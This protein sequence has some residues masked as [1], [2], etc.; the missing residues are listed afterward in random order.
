M[1]KVTTTYELPEKISSIILKDNKEYDSL[2]YHDYVAMGR[3]LLKNIDCYQARIA[4]YACKICMIRHGGRST[5]FYTLT[6]YAKE[7]NIS[8]NTLSTWTQVYRHVIVRLGIPLEELTKKVWVTATRTQERLSWENRR[9]NSEKGTSR[10][11]IKYKPQVPKEKI[12]KIWK[13]EEDDKP[14]FYSEFNGWNKSILHIKLNVVKR[15]LNLVHEGDISEMMRSL[16]MI[17]DHLNEF[18]TKKKKKKKKTIIVK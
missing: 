17:S 12:E 6:D 15:D 2:N 16:D 9:D 4:F 7:L 11:N 5:G 18:L 14:S 3:E 10:K 1:E 8:H 13:E